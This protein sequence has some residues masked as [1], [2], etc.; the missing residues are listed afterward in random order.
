MLPDKR[1]ED[2]I[3][4]GLVKEVSEDVAFVVVGE[5]PA[6]RKVDDADRLRLE[7][8]SGEDFVRWLEA[9]ERLVEEVSPVR[10]DT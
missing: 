9:T 8:M 6:P 5:K 4:A 1:I 7:I 3:F 2:A 10:Q